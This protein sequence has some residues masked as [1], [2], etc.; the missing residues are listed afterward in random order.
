MLRVARSIV[1]SAEAAEDVVQDTWVAVL[2]SVDGFE[3]RSMLKTWL[4]RI[5]MNT[6]RSRRLRAARTVC[7]STQPGD[8]AVWDGMLAR[9]SPEPAGP[10][11]HAISAE[12]WE[13]IRTSTARA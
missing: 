7:W 12:A 13:M 2:R 9:R 10:L 4:M 3:G 6:A 1:G 8:A 5:L 11:E